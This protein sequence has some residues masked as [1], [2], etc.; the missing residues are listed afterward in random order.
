MK[1][2]G[3]SYNEEQ[4]KPTQL[5]EISFLSQSPAELRKISA[6]L[7]EAAKLL[8]DGPAFGHR[9]LSI[10]DKTWDGSGP[11]VVVADG[12]SFEQGQFRP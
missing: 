10:E 5:R 8:E 2:F 11:D 6:F 7:T 1:I 4:E 12:R 9:H 3:Y